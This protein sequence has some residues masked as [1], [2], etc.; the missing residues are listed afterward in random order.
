MST[1]GRQ[2]H[3][4]INQAEH[5]DRYCFHISPSTEAILAIRIMEKA[6]DPC[7]YAMLE[8]ELHVLTVTCL[9]WSLSL[10]SLGLLGTVRLFWACL[11]VCAGLLAGCWRTLLPSFSFIT[12]ALLCPD[13]RT[14]ARQIP[15][16][17]M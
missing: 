4:L 14:P 7:P 3:G 9:T 8:G 2:G 10:P 15:A 12:S 5:S 6:P 16:Q 13:I 1:L 17:N 11:P